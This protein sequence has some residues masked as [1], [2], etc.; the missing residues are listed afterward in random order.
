MW[1]TFVWLVVWLTVAAAAAAAAAAACT[2]DERSDDMSSAAPFMK[3][4]DA[5][6]PP[7]LTNDLT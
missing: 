1:L 7:S 2:H 6:C 4:S 5:S 3:S